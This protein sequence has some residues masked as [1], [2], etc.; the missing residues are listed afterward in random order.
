M[1]RVA[2]L[3]GGRRSVLR[4]CLFATTLFGVNI[5]GQPAETPSGDRRLPGKSSCALSGALTGKLTGLDWRLCRT[6][7]PRFP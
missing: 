5:Y 4:S 1:K 6:S 7:G 3:G 2:L